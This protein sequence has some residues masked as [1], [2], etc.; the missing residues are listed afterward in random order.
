MSRCS[1]FAEISTALDIEYIIVICAFSCSCFLR[2]IHNVSSCCHLSR[3]QDIFAA[4]ATRKLCSV[5]SH[6][7]PQ[8]S[9]IY[10]DCWLLV[11]FRSRWFKLRVGVFFRTEKA[12]GL[13][14][15][16]LLSSSSSSGLTFFS[17]ETCKTF[18]TPERQKHENSASTESFR[19]DC[20]LIN[21]NNYI[22]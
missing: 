4:E 21:S 2:K 8:S 7:S 10:R 3:T 19:T 11:Q 6:R 18:Q 14:N 22:F 13:W 1:L 20:N 12:G 16:A 15:T 9:K 5:F 17:G